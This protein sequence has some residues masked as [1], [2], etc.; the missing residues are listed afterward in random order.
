MT[1]LVVIVDVREHPSIKSTT[2]RRWDRSQSH[3]LLLSCAILPATDGRYDRCLIG[4]PPTY[5][6]HHARSS[7]SYRRPM[8]NPSIVSFIA[9]GMTLR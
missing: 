1:N 4:S 8:Y 3:T 9:L 6:P 2:R 5:L 7:R